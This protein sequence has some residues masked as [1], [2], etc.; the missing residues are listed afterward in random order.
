M[1]KHLHSELKII[2]RKDFTSEKIERGFSSDVKFKLSVQNQNFLLRLS[3]V[4][5]YH[6]RLEEF[7]VM[8]SLVELGVKCN[9]PIHFGTVEKSN[10]KIC[11]AL[12]SYIEGDDAERTLANHSK[13]VQYEIGFK[14]GMDLKKINSIQAKENTWE[15]KKVKK[16][17]SYLSEY[18]KLDYSFPKDGQ[19]ENF[20]Y[21]NIKVVS[22]K[23]SFLQHDDFHPGNIITRNGQYAGV[24]DFNRIVWGDPIHEFVKLGWFGKEVSED[25]A[26]G[27]LYG[28][29]KKNE[30][31]DLFWLKY[32]VYMAMSIYS[33]VVWH[34]KFFPSLLNKM[35]IRLAKILEEH[36]YFEKIKPSW[37]K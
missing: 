11:F 30:I 23:K 5:N 33:T 24:I 7:K 22:T 15:E 29:F 2:L 1:N 12:Y 6:Q 36:Q 20:I 9:K 35:N 8:K 19:I 21:K 17:E 25:F 10:D 18:K 31:D 14:A 13:K 4:E 28:Y 16:H 26:K 32:S 3:S 37:V 27:Q 34:F